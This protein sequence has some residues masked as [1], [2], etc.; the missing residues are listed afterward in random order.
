M[1]LNDML[2]KCVS[3]RRLHAKGLSQFIPD[4]WSAATEKLWSPALDRVRST[5]SWPAPAEQSKL[6][7]E[8]N[9]KTGLQESALYRVANPFSASNVCKQSLLEIHFMMRNQW[10]LSYDIRMTWSNLFPLCMTKATA[11]S[12]Q[13]NL[14]NFVRVEPVSCAL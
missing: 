3:S 9:E 11:L 12:T 4:P 2:T 7:E 1:L 14:S 13:C 5:R 8:I 10:S 6:N